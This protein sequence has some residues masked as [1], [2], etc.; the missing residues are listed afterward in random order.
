[1]MKDKAK[2]FATKAHEGQWRKGSKAPYIT[3]PIRV[4]NIL[5]EAGC[6][7]EVICAGYLHD[8]VE[9]T[10][11][12]IQEIA[13]QFGKHI[14]SLV[15][16]N[17]E[18]KTLPWEKRKQQTIYTLKTLN[19]EVKQLIIADKLDNLLS[20]EADLQSFGE[21]V[22]DHFH[23]PF[24]K[25]KWYYQSIKEVMYHGISTKEAPAFFNCYE[26]TVSRVF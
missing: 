3:H 22:W 21:V 16:A 11:T 26:K 14:T 12:T 15:C 13:I 2:E 24:D 20:I 17:T 1:M 6:S 8:V 18:N 10:A 5:E 19:M 7:E 4:A 23:A 9:D 25:Q